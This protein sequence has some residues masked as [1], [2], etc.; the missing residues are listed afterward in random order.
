MYKYLHALSTKYAGFV[1]KLLLFTFSI[2]SFFISLKNNSISFAFFSSNNFSNCFLSSSVSILQSIS[3]AF[4]CFL[5]QIP[6]YYHVKFYVWQVNQ[7]YNQFLFYTLFPG[8]K[9]HR[10]YYSY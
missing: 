5:S 1:I 9:D 3:N 4:S 7:L 8:I 10:I 2:T 6:K